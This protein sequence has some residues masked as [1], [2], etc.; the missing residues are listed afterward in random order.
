MMWG[1]TLFRRFRPPPCWERLACQAAIPFLSTTCGNR[2]V[3]HRG[4]T[5]LVLPPG[6]R[7]EALTDQRRNGPSY[8]ARTTISLPGKSLGAVV[9]N[10]DSMRP[11]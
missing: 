7:R 4:G 5:H 11:G 8:P 3:P 6:M 1:P 9:E 2:G 10:F